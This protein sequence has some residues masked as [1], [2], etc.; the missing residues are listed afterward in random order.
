LEARRLL[1]SI[2]LPTIPA[3]TFLVTSY[4]AKGDGT[5]N[6]T[7]DIQNAINAAIAAGGGTVEIPAASAAYESGPITLG[8]NINLQIDSGAELQAIP[9]SQYPDA[10][11][12]STA[13]DFIEAKSDSNVEISGSGTIDG[14]GSAWWSAYN[15]NNS[16]KRPYLIYFDD[17]NIVLV[18]NV[19]LQNSPMFHV[20]FGATNNVTIDAITINT[21]STSPNTDGIDPAGSNYLI[22]NCNISTGDDDVAVKPEDVYCSNITIQNCTIGYGHGISV[23]GETNEG[24]DGLTVTNITFTNTV[25]GIRLKADR[26]NGGVVENLSYSDI[27]MTNV[28]Y[29][30]LIDSYYNQSNDIPT[31]PASDPGQTYSAGSTP[32]WEDISISNLTS[33]NSA[34]NSNAGIIFGLPEA[35]VENL[36]FTNVKI[37]AEIGMQID[38]ARDISFDSASHITVSS[39]NDVFGSTTSSP[40]YLSPYDATLV[41]AGFV[42][43][44]IGSPTVPTGTSSSLYDPDTAQWTIMGDGAGFA[45]T[46]DQYNF[47]YTPITGDGG[48]QAALQT[49]SSPGG[50]AV[51]QAGVMIRAS[52]N[53]NDAFAAVMQTTANQMVFEWRSSSG[54]ALQ[55]SAPVSMVINAIYLRLLRSGTSYSAYYSVGGTVWY[56][57]GSTETISGIGTTANAGLAVTSDDNGAL[58]TAVFVKESLIASVANENLFYYGSSEFDNSATTPSS[59]DQNAIATDKSALVSGSTATTASFSNISS[60]SDGLNGI[61]IDF[62]NLSTSG[63]TFSASDFAFKVGNNSNSSTWSTAPAPTAVA[64]WTGNDG[65]TFADIVWANNAIQEEWLQVTVLADANTHLVNNVVFYFGNEIGATGASTATTGNGPVLRVT[66]ADVVNTENNASLLQTVPI[67]N[68][69]DFNRDGKVTSTDVV[70]CQNNATLLGGIVLITVGGSSGNVILDGTADSLVQS[71]STTTSSGSTSGV[72][73]AAVTPTSSS[74][75]K[76]IHAT[77]AQVNAVRDYLQHH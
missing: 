51:P 63:V 72:Q 3:G 28:E 40:E 32:L 42:N 39:G 48:I 76:L 4:G 26:G 31:N 1:S 49:L 77:P 67:T 53:A 68:I 55:T 6:N 60:Y 65:D 70:L 30:I 21:P 17:S 18:E 75:P 5:T 20:A 36:S 33:T 16:I 47:S 14:N 71:S 2:P 23:G 27:T 58:A 10:G 44:D 11:S 7:T 56:Q 61:L 66:S 62:A 25:N 37:T 29:P 64:T 43:L 74:D 19:L 50:S 15:S 8:N 45:S 69:Y 73:V 52:T 57:I 9:Y 46:S 35:P 24:L 13:I 54:G 12:T 41:A 34:S 59:A 22:E 38:H